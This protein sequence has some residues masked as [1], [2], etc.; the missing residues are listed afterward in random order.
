MAK[1][2]VVRFNVENTKKTIALLPAAAIMV[3]TGVVMVRALLGA[4][5][6]RTSLLIFLACFAIMVFIMGI[7]GVLQTTSRAPAAVIND[8]GIW[9]RNFGLIPWDN[10]RD[11]YAYHYKNSPLETIGIHVHNIKVLASQG[12]I[13][14]RCSIF[15]SKLLGTPPITLSNLAVSNRTIIQFAKQFMR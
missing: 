3:A 9:V 1:E 8:D 11:V 7:A 2:L 6:L 10:I 14:A 13:G 15:C 12:S 5:L 4:G